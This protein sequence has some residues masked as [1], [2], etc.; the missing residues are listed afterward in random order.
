MEF[1]CYFQLLSFYTLFFVPFDIQ[2]LTFR[3]LDFAPSSGKNLFSCDQWIKLVS[4]T[5]NNNST[6][7]DIEKLNNFINVPTP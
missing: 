7:D 1:N 5:V 4:E 2:N 3:R 6:A